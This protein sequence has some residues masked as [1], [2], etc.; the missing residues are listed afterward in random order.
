VAKVALRFGC[1]KQSKNLERYLIYKYLDISSLFSLTMPLSLL[2]EAF[3]AILA[4]S[5]HNKY[6]DS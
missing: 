3:S 4:A 6:P 2:V 1:A 5:E